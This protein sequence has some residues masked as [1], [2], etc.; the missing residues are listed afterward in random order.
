LVTEV[1][2]MADDDYRGPVVL[3]DEAGDRYLA[4]AVLSWV[5]D[6][7]DWTGVLSG[8]DWDEIAGRRLTLELPGNRWWDLP[9]VSSVRI[10]IVVGPRAGAHGRIRYLVPARPE[11]TARPARRVAS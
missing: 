11:H 6:D 3:S 10:D 8:P 5:D 7:G 1:G 9:I 2:D 4:E